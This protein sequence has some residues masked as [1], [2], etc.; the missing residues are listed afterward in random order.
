MSTAVPAGTTEVVGA[1]ARDTRAG[2]LEMA[3]AAAAA[4]RAVLSFG[5]SPMGSKK[6][7]PCLA[8]TRERTSQ[9]DGKERRMRLAM[10]VQAP[11]PVLVDSCSSRTGSPVLGELDSSVLRTGEQEAASPVAVH[12][13][14]WGIVE[15][16]PEGRK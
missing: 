15:L 5:G 14:P 4:L 8:E 13:G 6:Q 12:T 1:L 7:T 2:P 3:P 11:V 9:M 10:V 16:E